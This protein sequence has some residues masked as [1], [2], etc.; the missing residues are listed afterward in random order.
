MIFLEKLDII[1][2]TQHETN[3]L[4]FLHPATRHFVN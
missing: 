4:S 2:N 1:S 3:M